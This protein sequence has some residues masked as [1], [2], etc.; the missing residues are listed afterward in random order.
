MRNSY[1]P[2]EGKYAMEDERVLEDNEELIGFYGVEDEDYGGSF[3]S[4]GFLVLV[5]QWA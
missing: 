5:K 2:Y 4:F 1:N 3:I